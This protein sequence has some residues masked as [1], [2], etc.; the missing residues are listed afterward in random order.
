MAETG[1]GLT[2][3]TPNDA[4]APAPPPQ[5]EKKDDFFSDF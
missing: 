5:D 3:A 2:K 1:K 4:A